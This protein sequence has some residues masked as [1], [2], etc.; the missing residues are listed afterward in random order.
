[1]VLIITILF[2][3]SFIFAEDETLTSTT[4]YPSPYG[5]YNTLST[6]NLEFQQSDSANTYDEIKILAKGTTSE[7][8]GFR[9]NK[10]DTTNN[11]T[12]YTTDNRSLFL[13]PDNTG[14]VVIG[15][16][17][18]VVSTGAKLIVSGGFVEPKGGLI[19]PKFT[20][21]SGAPT[22]EGSIWIQ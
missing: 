21:G 1:M 5:S 4:Y 10:T 9:Y 15:P 12:I 7:I 19:I 17:T 6:N 18:T 22:E 14:G 3:I 8:G 2:F 11:F 20:G 16:A 13:I